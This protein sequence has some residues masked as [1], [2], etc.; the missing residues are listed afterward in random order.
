MNKY[1]SEIH[2]ANNSM[3]KT[4]VIDLDG[5]I[6]D[7]ESCKVGCDYSGYPKTHTQL[8]RSKC[9]LRKGMKEFL[10]HLKN[11]GYSITI[12]T[13]RVSSESHVTRQ[14]L[15]ENK[16]HYDNISFDKPRGFIYIDD[17]AHEF[18]TTYEAFKEIQLRTQ[19]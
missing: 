19:K 7:F 14:W 16:I 6:T 11:Q 12:F 9:P 1:L 3:S 17:L 4:I 15:E 5:V 13:S 18:T 2:K 10:D 8:Q